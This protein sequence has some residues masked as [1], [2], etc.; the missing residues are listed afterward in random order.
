MRERGSGLVLVGMPGAGKS[1][2]GRIV[3]DRLG[4]RY[5]DIDD[6]FEQL[7]RVPVPEYAR[8][9]GEASFRAL[10]ADVVEEAV[11]VSG[12]VIATGGGS[13]IDPL[14]R[15]RLWSYGLVAFLHA[16]DDLLAARLA[17]DATPRPLLEP[18]DPGSLSA[19]R[20]GRVHA[21]QAADL[22]LDATRP[23]AEL[24]GEI[25]AALDRAETPGT[26]LRLFD[27]RLPRHHP[28]GPETTRIVIGH[29]LGRRALDDALAELDGGEPSA[30]LDRRVAD[31]LPEL[32][33]ALPSGR[34]LTIAAG[35]QVKTMRRLA[36]ILE[37]LST[38]EAERGAPL[39]AVG[40]GTLGDLAGTAAALYARGVPLVHVPT[41]WLAQADSAIGGKVAVDLGAAKNAAGAFWP[42][43]AVISDTASLARLPLARRRD[44]MAESLKAGLIGDPVLWRLV[45]E[46]G[47]A[48]LRDDEAARYAIVERAVRVKLA[49]VERDPYE[50]GERRTLNLGH[51]IGHAVEVESNFRLAHGTAVALGLRAVAAIAA[52]RGADPA[53]PGE[54][55]ATLRNLGF[56][57]HRSF[58]PAAVR[59]AMVSDKKRRRGRQRWILPM[60]IGEVVEVDDV[61]PAELDLALAT[62][63][64]SV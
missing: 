11:A 57:L 36:S 54:L 12:A 59:A 46:R 60:A 49:I 1:A 58:D 38:N 15:W 14:S 3:A 51:T 52:A 45:A 23:P 31:R 25:L 41:T 62:I 35:E 21:Y 30:I 61:T 53:L 2:V 64:Q 32:L 6:L 27:A 42:P 44:G 7:H 56:P 55:D 9:H 63:G 16:P 18:Y 29:T 28:L 13:V 17:A 4:R 37:W 34:C 19:L 39:I 50:T 5:L 22:H 48:A 40:G 8:R 43:A 33:A 10:E 47:R 20:A 26:Q 24:A